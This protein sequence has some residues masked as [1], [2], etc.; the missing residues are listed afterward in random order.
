MNNMIKLYNYKHKQQSFNR[1]IERKKN[2]LTNPI[3]VWKN[4]TPIQEWKVGS[5]R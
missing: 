4:E 2:S 1:L 5:P 3:S